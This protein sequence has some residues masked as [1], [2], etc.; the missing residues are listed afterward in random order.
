MRGYNVIHPMGWDAF[1]LPAENAAIENKVSPE[2]WTKQVRIN[3]SHQYLPVFILLY[4]FSVHCALCRV[5]LVY[6]KLSLLY[7]YSY[8]SF[9]DPGFF[10][11]IR[12]RLF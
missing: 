9:A 6:G 8:T 1:G 7:W 5:D 10:V 11:W 4:S 3:Y 2:K 12:I